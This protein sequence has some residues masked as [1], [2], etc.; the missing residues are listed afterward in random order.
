MT[1]TGDEGNGLAKFFLLHSY[2]YDIFGNTGFLCCSQDGVAPY[3]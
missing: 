1:E 2:V 3:K